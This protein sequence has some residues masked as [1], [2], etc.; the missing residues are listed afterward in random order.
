MNGISLPRQEDFSAAFL[1]GFHHVAAPHVDADVRPV[2]RGQ[3]AELIQ[4]RLLLQLALCLPKPGTLYFECMYVLSC[5]R[6][7]SEHHLALL[8]WSFRLATS[9]GS[10][11]TEV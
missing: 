6:F 3:L 9:M 7:L 8:G 5:G 10:A 4:L 11:C 1:C 2:P